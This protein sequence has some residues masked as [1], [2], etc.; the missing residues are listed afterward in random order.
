MSEF[1]HRFRTLEQMYLDQGCTELQAQ[2]LAI[3]QIQYEVRITGHSYNCEFTV[4]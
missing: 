2:Q 3:S 4:A 1:E